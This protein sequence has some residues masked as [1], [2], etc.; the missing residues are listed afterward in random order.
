MFTLKVL[1]RE[2]ALDLK[3]LSHKNLKFE[4]LREKPSKC[5][6][7]HLLWDQEE[8]FGEKT[9]AKNLT[10]LC[11]ESINVSDVQ[12]NIIGD[13]SLG[14]PGNSCKGNAE[15]FSRIRSIPI[16][17]IYMYKLYMYRIICMYGT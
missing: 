6:I 3:R 7:G 8:L 4:Y 17:I 15:K 16:F 12:I 2:T 5:E 1:S 10:R 14:I 13:V 11:L 9:G